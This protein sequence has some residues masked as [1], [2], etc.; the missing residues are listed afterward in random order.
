MTGRDFL[1]LAKTLSASTNEAARRTSVSRAYYALYHYIRDYLIS[2]GIRVTTE[3]VEHKRMI[4][5]LKNTGIDETKYIGEKIEEIR[6]KRNKADYELR[7]MGFNETTCALY[8][9]LAE[10]LFSQLDSIDNKTLKDR[11]VQYAKSI[12]EP[13]EH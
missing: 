2:A 10:T 4:R 8:C 12:N 11:F 7:D 5:Y 3:P 1:T 9:V 13:Y 6:E